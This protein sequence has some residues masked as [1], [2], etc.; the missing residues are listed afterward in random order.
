MTR[1]FYGSEWQGTLKYTYISISAGSFGQKIENTKDIS[2]NLPIDTQT[3]K[4][5]N[6]ILTVYFQDAV[7]SSVNNVN[8]TSGV[9][10]AVDNLQIS[11]SLTY[12]KLES[13]KVTTVNDSKY[14]VRKT[15]RPDIV[16]MSST[17]VT[18]VNHTNYKNIF[19]L[20]AYTPF[21]YNVRW[22]KDGDAECK[23]LPAL[24]AMYVGFCAMGMAG[25]I[26][27]PILLLLVKQLHDGGYLHLWK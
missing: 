20:N 22:R 2:V 4:G 26:L 3:S 7:A 18:V 12:V 11:D 5:A 13:N 14:N 16:A 23:P 8:S 21:T 15:F 6:I 27:G 25:M 24:L 9:Y 17:D 1:Y 10:M 19:W